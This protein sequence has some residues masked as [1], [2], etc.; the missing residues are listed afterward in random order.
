MIL[1]ILGAGGMGRDMLELARQI[2]D[3]QHRWDKIIFINNGEKSDP[4]DGIKTIGLEEAVAKYG[5]ELEAIIAVGEPSLREKIC[6]DLKNNA[7]Q[8]ATL[9]HPNVHVPKNAKIGSG[10]A[11]FS[12][13]FIAN[14][15]KIGNNSSILFNSILGHDAVL[16]EGVMLSHLSILAGMC[17]VGDYTYIGPGVTVRESTKIGKYCIIAMGSTVFEDVED[18]V[19]VMGYPARPIKRNKKH[20]VF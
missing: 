20:R 12:G 16:G 2:E 4:I 19:M 11:I 15:S 5:S 10:V 14:N 13:A 8:G 1:A 6:N 7:I 17:Q 9:I 3:N 18:E